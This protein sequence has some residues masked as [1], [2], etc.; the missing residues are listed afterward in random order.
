MNELMDYNFG[1]WSDSHNE[2]FK[3][4]LVTF[5]KTAD[6]YLLSFFFFFFFDKGLDTERD[7]SN[8]L[9]IDNFIPH[10]IKGT[11]KPSSS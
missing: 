2:L 10:F 9:R 8:L 3:P 4:S 6:I 7:L 1:G 5:K 11:K